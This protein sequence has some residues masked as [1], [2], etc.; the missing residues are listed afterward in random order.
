M[1]L[2]IPTT[3]LLF[4]DLITTNRAIFIDQLES[5][6]DKKLEAYS[7]E[8]KASFQRDLGILCW[9]LWI[10]DGPHNEI[11][12]VQYIES[13]NPATFHNVFKEKIKQ[14]RF[15]GWLNGIFQR[16][17]STEYSLLD[18]RV[19]VKKVLDLPIDPTY[20]SQRFDLCYLL[21]LLSGK[22][23]EHFEYCRAAMNERREPTIAACKAFGMIDLKKWIQESPHRSYVLYYQKMAQPID[24]DGDDFFALKDDPKSL[25]ATK[26]LRDQTGLTFEELSPASF[27]IF[28]F[29]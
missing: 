11:F 5:S 26:T 8:E 14:N 18:S 28:L 23:D 4:A 22:V 6:P 13:Q 10:Q 17:L 25:E 9:Q 20:E 19:K 3:Q 7:E 2:A 1:M 29:P 16:D 21:P 24:Q 12:C 15:A 27:S